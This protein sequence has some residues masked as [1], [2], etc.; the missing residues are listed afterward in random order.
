MATRTGTRPIISSFR[1]A[2]GISTATYT[3]PEPT[4]QADSG[5]NTSSNSNK[6]PDGSS[7][8]GGAAR[9]LCRAVRKTTHA[10]SYSE[11]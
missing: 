8:R 6:I 2:A 11:K 10:E 7:L 4:R 5:T 9:N 3:C 1:I